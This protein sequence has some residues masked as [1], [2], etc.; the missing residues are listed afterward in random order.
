[1]K[2]LPRS[3]SCFVCGAHNPLGFQLTLQTDGQK[4]FA[5]VTFRP[6][7]VGFRDT[8]HGG[9]LA[10]LL[11]EVM[12]WA[13]GVGSGRF[14]Y[15]AEMNVRYRRPVPPGVPVIAQAVLTENRKG[16]L[17]LASGSLR[18][19]GGEIV[20]TEATGKY[21]AMDADG[22]SFMTGDFLE[23]PSPILGPPPAA[24]SQ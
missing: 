19:P 18:D 2:P 9:L 20:Y 7:H 16:R 1:M 13:C 15:C 10:T 21:M 12:V 5:E 14:A 23:N 11:D 4:V 3:R 22:S 24:I 6:E 17:L 8:I